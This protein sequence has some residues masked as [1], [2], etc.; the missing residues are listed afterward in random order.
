MPIDPKDPTAAL[1]RNMVD[2]RR[3]ENTVSRET[4]AVLEAAFTQ[5]IIDLIRL[6]PTAVTPGRRTRRIN[7]LMKAIQ[8]TTGPAYSDMRKI[9]NSSLVDVAGVQEGFALKQLDRATIGID[10]RFSSP[11]TRAFWRSFVTE[12]RIRGSP[13]SEWWANQE[14]GVRTSIRRELEIGLGQGETVDDLVRR[15][16]GRAVG[17]KFVDGKRVTRFAGGTLRIF[18][19]QAEAIVRTAVNQ[20]SN[21]ALFETFSSNPEVT[22]SYRYTATLDA[23]TSDICIS[24]DGQEFEYTDPNRR[25]PPQHFACRSTMVPIVNF[26]ELGL[27]TPIAAKRA[28]KTGPSVSRTGETVNLKK[29]G[30]VP[31]T[32]DYAGWLRK[33]ND[34]AQNEILGV[35]RAN[36]FRSNK[37]DLRTIVRKDNSTVSLADLQKRNA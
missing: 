17:S 16:R 24:L 36:L 10:V 18:T 20:I 21:D 9:L 6:D 1:V 28:V 37:L 8:G 3:F 7:A 27:D 4:T 12:R 23:R 30:P 15:V 35:G 11:E 13:L 31:A 22:T 33:Q 25:Q 26:E 34:A 14:R 2:M 32:T 29:T 19:R 5:I